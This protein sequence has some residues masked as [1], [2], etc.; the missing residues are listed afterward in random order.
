VDLVSSISTLESALKAQSK[1]LAIVA[2]N[3]S[4]K[5]TVS[6]IPG[7]D[8]YKSQILFYINKFYKQLNANVVEVYKYD[9]DQTPF[10]L[11]FEPHHPAADDNGY[12]K[13]PNIDSIIESADSKE[14]GVNYE[15][16]TNAINASKALIMKTLEIIN[17]G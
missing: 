14:V 2:Q 4:N 12:V 15:V 10:K 9:T 11:K 13:Y 5:E 16:I 6:S 7:G 3:I 17:K 8:P 1:R